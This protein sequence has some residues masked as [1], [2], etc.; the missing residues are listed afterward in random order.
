MKT[1]ALLL[2]EGIEHFCAPKAKT[3]L[4]QAAALWYTFFS[5]TCR[6]AS[7]Y[8]LEQVSSKCLFRPPAATSCCF[9]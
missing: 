7:L 6:H 2:G 8:W 5:S 3:L 4:H 1:L 9:R